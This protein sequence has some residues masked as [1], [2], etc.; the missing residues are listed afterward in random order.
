[1]KSDRHEA[2]LRE[3]AEA[4]GNFRLLTD[5]RFRLLALLPIASAATAAFKGDAKSA[6]DAVLYAFGLL[7]TLGVLTY[8]TRNDQLYNALIGRCKAIERT[9]GIWDG[10]YGS[11]PR[12]W[13]EIGGAK[14]RWKVDHSS[15]VMLI[16]SASI[17]L[18]LSKLLGVF[19]PP[20]AAAVQAILLTFLFAFLLSQ[21]QEARLIS[22]RRDAADAVA[23]VNNKALAAIP[24]D[25]KFIALCA[26]LAGKKPE[27]VSARATFYTKSKDVT[28]F[29]DPLEGADAASRLVALLTDL[30][31]EWIYICATNQRGE[32]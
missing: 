15:G 20:T 18:W 28:Y 17:A 5:I 32:L 9:L 21:N 25:T 13:L 4:S 31:P 2:L 7:V 8:H 26:K 24:S 27:V 11:R 30:T 19:I 6:D 22:L 12:A 10:A 1:M 29:P 14:Y 23:C 16:Y 3:Y